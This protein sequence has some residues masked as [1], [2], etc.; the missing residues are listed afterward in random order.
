[1]LAELLDV[2]PAL[3]RAWLKRGWLVPGSV[4]HQLPLVDFAEVTIA[5]Q[6]A[7]LHRAGVSSQQ[8]ARKL[9]QIERRW[10]EME[11]PLAE[12]TFVVDGSRLLVRRG[13]DLL[14]AAGQRQF[15]FGALEEEDEVPATIPAA[16]ALAGRGHPPV[17]QLV[18]WAEELE[19]AGELA[20]AAEMYRSAMLAAG[21]TPELCFSLAE[22]LYRL[23][24]RSGAR[25]RYAMA[26]EL[27][28]DFVEARCNL[29][30]VLAEMG[31]LELGAA[32]LEGALVRHEEYADAHYHLARIHGERGNSEKSFV[33][34]ERFLSLAPH[35]P[36]ADEAR[37]KLAS[38]TAPHVNK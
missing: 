27:H 37:H 38:R 25:E 17:E 10:P 35:S 16:A 20:P 15:D 30:C 2:S 23:G 7:E 34:W 18:A 33:H 13:N 4:E 22:V 19:E 11:R 1:M 12:L 29:G 5:R 8:L 24:D 26:V 36:W 21:P 3:V 31:E 9:A 32:A 14:D 28:E 6:L